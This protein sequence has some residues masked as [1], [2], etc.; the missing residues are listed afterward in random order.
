MV[1]IWC[2]AAALAGPLEDGVAALKKGDTVAARSLLTQAVEADPDNLRAH[3]ELG[4]AHWTLEDWKGA[5]AAWE[6]VERLDPAKDEL[7]HWL[8]SARTRAAEPIA[9]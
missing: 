6:T 9:T 1:G 4:W 5:T 7:Q 8:G 2:I 3:W